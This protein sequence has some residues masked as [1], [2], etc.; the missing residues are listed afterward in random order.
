MKS[1]PEE[2]QKAKLLVAQTEAETTYLISEGKQIH[3]VWDFDGVLASPLSDDI[4]DLTGKNLKKFFEYEMRL[5]LSPP[6]PG[7]WLP[8]AKKVGTLHVSQDIVTARSSFLAFR[9]IMFCMWHGEKDPSA[10]MR[11]ILQIGHQPKTENSR[12]YNSDYCQHG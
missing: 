9:I 6:R 3:F 8:L 10:W 1:S 4:F 2:I 7:I 11:W 5:F 12:G